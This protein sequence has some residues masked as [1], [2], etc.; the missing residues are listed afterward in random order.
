MLTRLRCSSHE[1][2]TTSTRICATHTPHHKARK[3]SPSSNGSHGQE[4]GQAPQ[5]QATNEQPKN[6]KEHGACQQPTNLSDWQMALEGT[7]K[8]PPTLSSSSPNTRYQQ[9]PERHHLRAIRMLSQT[10]KG[11]T[12]PNAIH[13][14]RQQN[15][16]PWQSTH[17]DRRN[18]SSQNAIQ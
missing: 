4:Y 18:A 7:S 9:T 1:T 2:T 3:R 17:P 10:K 14:R 8:T 16:L 12:Q 13:G 6:T 5:L 15:Q 11:R